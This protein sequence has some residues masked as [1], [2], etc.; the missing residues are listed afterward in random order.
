MI[1]QQVVLIGSKGYDTS[2]Q[3]IFVK[4]YLNLREDN[5]DIQENTFHIKKKFYEPNAFIVMNHNKFLIKIKNQEFT[6]N[7]NNKCCIEIYIELLES[8]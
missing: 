5:G 8:Y 2:T 7:Q 1:G 6:I 4:Q 3:H